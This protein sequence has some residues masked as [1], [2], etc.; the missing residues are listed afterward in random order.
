[1]RGIR[2]RTLLRRLR[3]VRV[4]LAGAYLIGAAVAVLLGAVVFSYL[5][6]HTVQE[7]INSDL[8]AAASATAADLAAGAQDL[9]APTIGPTHRKKP[10]ASITAVYDGHGR[11]VDGEPLHLP[12]DPRRLV[13]RAGFAGAT[14]GGQS[15]RLYRTSVMNGGQR[16]TIIVGQSTGPSTDATD[17]AIQALFVLVPIAILLSGLGAWWIAGAALRPVERMRADAQRLSDSGARELIGSPGTSDALDRLTATFNQLLT[18]LHTA[19]DRRRDFVAD[20]GHELRTPLAVLQTEL[21]M[22]S[23][24]GRSTEDLLDSIHHAREEAA[25]VAALA[26][27]LLLLAQSDEPTRLVRPMPVEPAEIVAESVQAHDRDARNHRLTV[28]VEVVG[29]SMMATVDPAALRRIV[30]NLLSNAIRHTPPDGSVEVTVSYAV[31]HV[32]ITV[33]DTGEG[34]PSDFLPRAFERFARADSSRSR[35]ATGSGS[36]LGLSIVRTLARAHG[37]EAAARNRPEGGAEVAVRLP[38]QP[39]DS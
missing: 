6:T 30:D 2:W 38:L 34:F 19:M 36:G 18:R 31:R 10:L 28:E 29:R 4:R 22:A 33:A 9:T 1:M 21:E 17:D 39:G 3:G 23:R 13:T 24:S 15:F 16:W 25:R 32:T 20:A 14:I 12:V 5:L 37:G 8:R 11:L 26:E 27:D 7:S 35:S